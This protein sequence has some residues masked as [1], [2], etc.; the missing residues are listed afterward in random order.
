MRQQRQ[1]DVNERIGRLEPLPRQL[2]T[3]IA[4]DDPPILLEEI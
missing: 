4:I 2:D 1:V 3:V